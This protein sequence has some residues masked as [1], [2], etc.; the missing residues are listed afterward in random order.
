MLSPYEMDVLLM[1]TYLTS[2]RLFVVRFMILRTKTSVDA[3]AALTFAQM[4]QEKLTEKVCNFIVKQRLLE[5]CTC[6]AI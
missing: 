2:L 3:K 6:L 5:F 1:I 4:I